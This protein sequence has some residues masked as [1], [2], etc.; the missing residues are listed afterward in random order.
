MRIFQT[1]T[2]RYKESFDELILNEQG[3]FKKVDSVIY[4]IFVT[5]EEWAASSIEKYVRES[6]KNG[7]DVYM[8]LGRTGKLE[9]CESRILNNTQHMVEFVAPLDKAELLEELMRK[10]AA[11]NRELL[12]SAQE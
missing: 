12:A 8:G 4:S 1:S 5:A 6:I 10:F 3:T 2:L 7:I 11:D 9:M